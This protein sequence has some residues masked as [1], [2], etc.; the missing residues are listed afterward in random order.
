AEG[1]L[2]PEVVGDVTNQVEVTYN[3]STK[4]AEA[5]STAKI[6]DL[7]FTKE[8][9]VEFYSPNQAAGYILKIVNEG[10]S[11]ANDIN[12]KDEIGA[13]TVNTI[14]GSANQAFLQWAVQYVTGSSLTTVDANSL[15]V[16]KDIDYDI[17]LAPN[18]TITLYVI[19]LVNTEATGDIV[20]TA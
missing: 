11:Y 16:D 6:P 17:D 7:T 15:V 8:P 20:N 14:D 2:D 10:N 12:L 4:T 3:G 13:L 18:D 5:T 1:E 19:G 9:M